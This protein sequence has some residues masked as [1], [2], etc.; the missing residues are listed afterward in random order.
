MA[1]GAEAAELDAFRIRNLLGVAVA[2]LHRHVRIGVGVH[3]HVERAGRIELRQECHG[4]G[5][6]PEYRLDLSLDLRVRLIGLRGG[7]AVG[8]GL[9][10]G[11]M[12]GRGEIYVG[13]EFSLSAGFCVVGFLLGLLKIWT[14]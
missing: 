2:P 12:G 3:E 8:N 11:G 10:G 7:G 1:A 6:L 14:F 9:V 13:A 4:R 5:D